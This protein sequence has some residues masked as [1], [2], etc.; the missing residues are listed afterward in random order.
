MVGEG[1]SQ[2]DNQQCHLLRKGGEGK[3]T[4]YGI[5]KEGA[6]LAT[7]L[8]DTNGQEGHIQGRNMEALSEAN[9]MIVKAYGDR[10]PPGDRS[11]LI[12]SHPNKTISQWCI[13][14]EATAIWK[15]VKGS[16]RV[17][18]SPQQWT[19]TLPDTSKIAGRAKRVTDC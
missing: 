12:S 1:E 7:A 5:G 13:V 16:A 8:M 6:T 15:H 17:R 10:T 4:P 9:M 14:G 11:V 18:T 19:R 2:G 3:K